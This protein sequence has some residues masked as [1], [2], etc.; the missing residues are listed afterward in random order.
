MRGQGCDVFVCPV[1]SFLWKI[2]FTASEHLIPWNRL[3]TWGPLEKSR[4]D[5]HPPPPGEKAPLGSAYVAW[6]IRTCL[7]EVF[8]ESQFVDTDLNTPY[9]TGFEAA[10]EVNL[11]GLT[12]DWLLRVDSAA[13]VAYGPKAHTRAWA[14]A[15]HETWPELDGLLAPSVMVGGRSSVTV[16]WNDDV[17]PPRP[18]ISVPL[19]SPAIA[20]DIAREAAGISYRSNIVL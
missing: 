9:L 7:A 6:D 2:H 13:K 18:G 16:L 8:Q 12:D 17:F 20:A 3:R 10:R 15:I 11:A 4:W 5:P 14:R 19:N 1:G